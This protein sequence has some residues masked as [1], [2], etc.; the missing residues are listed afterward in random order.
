MK[1]R[2]K[3]W[4]TLLSCILTLALVVA[5]SS[6]AAAQ[7]SEREFIYTADFG[8]DTI[9]AFSFNQHNG[10]AG[11]VPGSPFPTGV[12]PV[13]LRHSP[14][15]RFV[16][17]VIN[18]EFLGRPCGFN[19][20]E[21][22]SYSVNARTGALTQIDDVVLSG[23]CSTGI[24]VDPTGRF[25]Y[26]SSFPSD[27]PK[28]G[29]I[30]GF[31]TSNG[32]LMPLPGSPFASPIEVGSGQQPAIDQLAIP[33]DGK[34]LYGSDPNDPS[35]ILIFDRDTQT[36][37]LAFRKA[38]NTGSA[39]GPIAITPA[40]SFLLA[41]G[42]VEIGS[43]APGLFEFSIGKHGNLTPVVGSPFHLPG[44]FGSS[45]TIS[46]DGEFV[47]VVG[48]F[49]GIS[50]KGITSFRKN[51]QGKL[52]LVPGSP[53][54]DANAAE[55]TFD[56]SGRFLLIPGAVFRIHSQTGAVSHVSDFAGAGGEAITVLRTCSDSDDEDRDDKG[57]RNDR[58]DKGC[59]QRNRDKD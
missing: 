18:S 37:T 47:A 6:R 28:V 13:G 19:N 20:G 45:V 54:G 42:A 16:Y 55:I 31:R 3:V 24:A 2:G 43:G 1:L 53:F 7:D 11:K 38:V 5:G 44:D 52:S 35:G 50:G 58:G 12:G 41:L 30:D 34:V 27:G 49:S 21:L 46:P 25:V 40:G 36:G 9:P 23:L 10:K 48:Q 22:I 29:I 4:L 56:P 26:A 57:E 33:P 39:F 32:H 17:V 59:N 51:A 15:G 14:D 8:N